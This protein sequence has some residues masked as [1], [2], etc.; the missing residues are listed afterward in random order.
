MFKSLMVFSTIV[1]ASQSFAMTDSELATSMR[2][3]IKKYYSVMKAPKLFFHWVDASDVTP[4]GQYNTEFPTNSIQFKEYIDKQGQKIFN[5][6]SEKDPDIAGPGLYMASEPT[7]SRS[8]GAKK[9]FG[10]IVG[11]VKSGTKVFTDTG[12]TKTSHID[13]TIL[14]ETAK[15]NCSVATYVDLLNTAEANC[16]KVK[17]LLVGKDVSF[18]SGRLYSWSSNRRNYCKQIVKG[19]DI[20]FSQI[21][22]SSAANKALETF[23][24][25]NSSLFSEVVGV[26]HMTTKGSTPL[27]N[28]ILSF[29]KNQSYNGF[30]LSSEAQKKSSSIKSMTD[31]EIKDFAEKY[32]YECDN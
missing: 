29:L 5:R 15:R 4:K 25:F 8:Y 31:S 24:V 32:I 2:E 19:R 23:V 7:I 1:F 17:Q 21:L 12:Y 13:P 3:D 27:A 16:T 9:T 10:L 22:D 6:R 14:S 26:T 30:D 18:T 11:L 28:Q 20:S